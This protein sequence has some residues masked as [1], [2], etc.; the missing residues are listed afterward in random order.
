MSALE[1][2]SVGDPQTVSAPLDDVSGAPVG[3]EGKFLKGFAISLW[4]NGGDDCD[5][6]WTRFTGVKKRGLFGERST[7]ADGAKDTFP[8]FWDRYEEDI[9]GAKELGSN[10]LRFSFEW[11]QI[12]PKRGEID[13]T[14][15]ARYHSLLDCMK[16]NGLVAVATLHHFTHPGWFQDLGG[17]E[18]DDSVP[19]FV[20]YSKFMFSEFGHRIRHWA[21]F[22]E[23]TCYT[24]CSYMAGLHSPGKS[25][26]FFMAGVVMKN[27][28]KAHVVAYRAMKAMEGGKEAMI[29]L[30]H[31]HVRF[32]PYGENWKYVHV[33]FFADW[34]TYWWGWEVVHTF[35]MTG[36]FTWSMPFFGKSIEYEYD[37]DGKPPLDFWGINYYTMGV[38]SPTLQPVTNEGGIMTDMGYTI[39]PDGLYEAIKK[40][41]ELGVP[42]YITETGVADMGDSKRNIMIKGYTNEVIR[43]VKDGYD[44]RGFMYW[45]LVDNFEWNMG[46]KTRF[47]V[48]QWEPD[49]SVDRKLRQGGKLLQR[50]YEAWPEN[51]EEMKRFAASA[52]IPEFVDI[53]KNEWEGEPKSWLGWVH[54]L[55]L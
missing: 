44:L 43:A 39:V 29:G 15:V 36:K 35:M 26:C 34:F 23:P 16:E 45:T 13:R 47:G 32:A 1:D 8:G 17:F 48:Y 42:M 11:A 46:Y 10:C 12:E 9:R 54:H 24:F 28:L 6:N 21:T 49:G 5:S 20:N 55:L 40:S 53:V 37:H 50:I 14:V 41:S 7:I 30:V 3:H 2:E 22:N 38:I 18:S 27:M 51:L 31:H 25:F 19:L 52:D 33:K 4:Q